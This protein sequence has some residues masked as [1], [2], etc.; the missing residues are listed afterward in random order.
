MLGEKIA[1]QAARNYRRLREK[2]VTIRKSAD[3]IIGT[4]CMEGGH[5]L[6]HED[7]D[8]DAMAE[9]LGLRWA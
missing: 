3:V 6:L 4:F 7:R 1:A 8:I 9:W 5:R 2:G